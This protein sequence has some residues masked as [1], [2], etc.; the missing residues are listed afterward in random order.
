MQALDRPHVTFGQSLQPG[1][2]PDETLSRAESWS[3]EILAAATIWGPEVCRHR[4]TL[5]DNGR[6]NRPRAVGHPVGDNSPTTPS[7]KIKHS[8]NFLPLSA[9]S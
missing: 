5:L 9:F 7:M 1:Q 8:L 6:F 3:M 4:S 2:Y